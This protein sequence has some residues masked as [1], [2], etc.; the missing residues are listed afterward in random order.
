VN[1]P[2]CNDSKAKILGLKNLN[3]TNMSV[4]GGPPDGEG[5]VHN[6]TDELFKQQDFIPA[7]QTAP[8]V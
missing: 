6:R 1:L 8:P 7:G 2:R 5:V 3:F 4:S